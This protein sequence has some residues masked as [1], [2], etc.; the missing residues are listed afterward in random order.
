VTDKPEQPESQPE[1]LERD[2]IGAGDRCPARVSCRSVRDECGGR[3]GQG[4]RGNL[5]RNY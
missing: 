4:P 1:F 3:R 5:S 2:D